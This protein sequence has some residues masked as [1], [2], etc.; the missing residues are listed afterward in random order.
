MCSNLTEL[1]QSAMKR[2]EILKLNKWLLL[3]YFTY[4]Y[5][6]YLL[7]CIHIVILKHYGDNSVLGETIMYMYLLKLSKCNIYAH[8]YTKVTGFGGL[9]YSFLEPQLRAFNL[10]FFFT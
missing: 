2:V 3:L 9:L 5:H 6:L 8:T 7:T 4:S 1:E 10:F